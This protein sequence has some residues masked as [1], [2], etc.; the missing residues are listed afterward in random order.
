ME[1]TSKDVHLSMNVGSSY[2]ITF[3][4][5][6]K[7]IDEKSRSLIRKVV[8]NSKKEIYVERVKYNRESAKLKCPCC[9]SRKA[10]YFWLMKSSAF[11]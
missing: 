9:G 2:Y 7:E 1:L 10:K 3:C 8:G 5:G 11:S 4:G 6:I